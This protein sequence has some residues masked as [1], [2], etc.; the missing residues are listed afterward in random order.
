MSKFRRVAGLYT[1]DY[2]LSQGPR[3]GYSTEDGAFIRRRVRHPLLVNHHFVSH[4]R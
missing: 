3:A 4:S 1:L 2:R